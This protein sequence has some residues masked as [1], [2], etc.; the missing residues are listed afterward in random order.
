MTTREV[1]IN[2]VAMRAQ[3]MAK[4]LEQDALI[5]QD[6]LIT[7]REQNRQLTLELEAAN[8][9]IAEITKAE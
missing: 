4:H 9:R 2:A 3:A 6:D 8:A 5:L 1:S 7:V